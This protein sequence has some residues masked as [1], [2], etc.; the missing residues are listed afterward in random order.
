[1]L[2][3]SIKYRS[4]ILLVLIGI[5]VMVYFVLPDNAASKIDRYL[6]KPVF[7]E[8]IDQVS[9]ASANQTIELSFLDG[10]WMLNEKLVADRQMIQVLFA[11][12]DQAIPKRKVAGNQ[13]DELS[14]RFNADAYHVKLYQGDELKKEFQVWGDPQ[15]KMTWFKAPKANDIYQ[16]VIPGYNAYVAFIFQQPEHEWRDK[17]VF[18]FNWQNFT[19][20]QLNYSARAEESFEISLSDDYFRVKD[21]PKTDTARLNDYLDYISML[22][23]RKWLMPGEDERADELAETEAHANISISNIAGRSRQLE[24]WSEPVK[25]NQYLARLDGKQL[26][27]LGGQDM[28]FLLRR[29]QDFQAINT[30]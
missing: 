29:K 21:L 10:R 6:F 4:I 2:D 5:T 18:D 9:I 14:Q 27:W 7:L 13:Q 12:I 22:E 17:L 23:T 24:L 16:V 20:L 3:H 1:M 25:S 8:Q 19:A 15:K 11:T 26:L 28:Q 30:E